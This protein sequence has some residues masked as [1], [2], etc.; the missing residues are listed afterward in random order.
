M[1]F[2]NALIILGGLAL[3]G[4]GCG[5]DNFAVSNPERGVIESAPGSYGGSETPPRPSGPF[6]ITSPAFADGENIPEKY[7]CNGQ[8]FSPPISFSNPP[9]GSIGLALIMEDPDSTPPATHWVLYNMPTDTTGIRDGD[10]PPGGVGQTIGGRLG[11]AGPCPSQGTHRYV[12]T[13]YA[14]DIPLEL[15]DHVTKEEVM[16]AMEG[17][18]VGTATLMGK[19]GK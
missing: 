16:K 17:H 12:F 8:D 5:R 14:V 18:I 6:M 11:Y 9:P 19:Y 15:E 1:M 13:L 4:A 10:V 7:T 3:V 2:R